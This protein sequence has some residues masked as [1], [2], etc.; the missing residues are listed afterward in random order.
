MKIKLDPVTLDVT[1]PALTHKLAGFD[2]HFRKGIAK[3][4]SNSMDMMRDIYWEKTNKA[5]GTHIKS[6][7]ISGMLNFKQN[8]VTGRPKKGD[9]F[10]ITAFLDGSLVAGGSHATKWEKIAWKQEY[11]GEI[12][13]KKSQLLTI[14]N[15]NVVAP[16]A[17]ARHSN[18]GDN[19]MWLNL[20]GTP[21]LVEKPKKSEGRQSRGA[22]TANK[23][24]KGRKQAPKSAKF[25]V[26]F[27]GKKSVTLRPKA[28]WADTLNESKYLVP[29]VFRQMIEKAK[30]DYK[31]GKIYK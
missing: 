27:W 9:D 24:R 8:Y 16:G 13:A 7:H 29:V 4:L 11:G 21:A 3:A 17:R 25:K 18:I 30:I 26:Y 28:F 23:S 19:A 22:A 14:P 1:L 6:N 5:T 12:R 31:S 15:L 2:D 20:K 10:E